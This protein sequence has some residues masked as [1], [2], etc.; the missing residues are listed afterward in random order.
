MAGTMGLSW[1]DPKLLALAGT[2]IVS[3][4]G[5]WVKIAYLS[6]D[7]SDIS[8]DIEEEESARESA[9]AGISAEIAIVQQTTQRTAENVARLC[10]A[11]EVACK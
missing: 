7:V 11:L 1:A 8:E 4:G 6:E 3:A 10:Q 2:I 9:D 5:A